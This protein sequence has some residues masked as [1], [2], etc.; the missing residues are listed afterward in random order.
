M[1]LKPPVTDNRSP[2]L[3]SADW[4]EAHLGA[5]RLLDG[6]YS[7]DASQVYVNIHLPGAQRFDIDIIKDENNP[8]PHMLPDAETMS[9][10]LSQLGLHPD[11]T[12]VVYDQQGLFGAPR[13][14]WMLRAYGFEN[15]FILEHG[16]PGWYDEKRPVEAGNELRPSAQIQVALRRE[17]LATKQDVKNA[18]SDNIQ[19]VDARA[20]ARF[21][22]NAPEPRLGMRSGHMPGAL[23]LPYTALFDGDTLK[24]LDELKSIIKAAGIDMMKPVIST[25]GSGVTA[26]FLCLSLQSLG[27]S[28]WQL[29]DG[30]WSEW[31]AA[32]DCDV[33]KAA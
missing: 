24:N 7:G 19:V 21:D 31:G 8:L 1:L 16:L 23:N 32:A 22:G 13:V 2:F 4:V 12:V 30:S 15:V 14:W 18:A 26:A 29:Y 25:C 9:H 11:D 10:H 17:I 33:V 3:V 28:N 20:A 27:I 6:S 5:L